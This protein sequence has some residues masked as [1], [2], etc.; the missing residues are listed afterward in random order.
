MNRAPERADSKLPLMRT[1][2][3]LFIGS[4]HDL[5][6]GWFYGRGVEDVSNT[7][8][9]R[10]YSHQMTLSVT[11]DGYYHYSTEAKHNYSRLIR[12]RLTWAEYD[13]EFLVLVDFSDLDDPCH[14]DVVRLF[15]S[16]A[17]TELLHAHPNAKWLT[18]LARRYISDRVLEVVRLHD[19]P[20]PLRISIHIWLDRLCILTD[21]AVNAEPSDPDHREYTNR[22]E[23]DL[24]DTFVEIGRPYEMLNWLNSRAHRYISSGLRRLGFGTGLD[25]VDEDDEEDT[26]TPEDEGAGFGAT[27]D[28]IGEV[29]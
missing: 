27:A 4:P 13:E 23:T 2:R 15:S 8:M 22:S 3:P 21:P 5:S 14:V 28:A 12:D 1:K 10:L 16:V 24:N 20:K 6:S 18:L 19:N 29:S 26:E 17:W 9:Q 11:S 7:I 25:D